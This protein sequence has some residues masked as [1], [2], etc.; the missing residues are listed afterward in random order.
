[1][2][3]LEET[4][5]ARRDSLVSSGK[6]PVPDSYQ[7]VSK[8]RI[9]EVLKRLD[10]EQADL[11]DAVFALL[12]NQTPS[13]FGKA[14]PETTF[15]GGA[16]TAQVAC[17]IGILQRDSTKLDREGRDYWIKPLR[18]IGA[19]EPVYFDSDGGDFL[20]GHPV[21]KS[22]NSAYRLSED[23]ITVLKAD[24]SEWPDLLDLW[25][26]DD[27]KRRRLAL[28]AELAAQTKARVNTKHSD[29]I[30][31]CKDV[32]APTF[33]PGF[34]VLYV[35]D[36][37][38]E[39]ISDEERDRM[40]DADVTLDLGDAMPDLLLWHPNREVLWVVEAVTSDG[41][42]DTRKVEQ[43]MELSKRAGKSGISFTTA[44]PSWRVAAA[45]QGRHKNIAPDTF[46]WIAEDGSKHWRA[47]AF[48]V[49]AERWLDS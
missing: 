33:L 20:V 24:L 15:S 8:G 23:F 5:R 2:A 32:Y 40:A 21:A 1:M 35:D 3:K 13:W 7:G 41:E 37:D 28:Q 46:V 16:T 27:A 49:S 11:V 43:L 9:R 17:H 39:R 22:P 19:V 47:E 38:G 10:L 4:V 30:R 36:S 48:E 26:E 6:Q 34:K 44:Y 25:N 18:D 12:D 45:R 42:V 14:P 31:L 29:L